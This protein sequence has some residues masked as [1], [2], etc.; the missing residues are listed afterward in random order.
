MGTGLQGLEQRRARLAYGHKLFLLATLPLILAVTAIAWVVAEQARQTSNREIAALEA[1]LIEAKKQE[2]R[3]YLSLARTAFGIIYGNAPP[4]DAVA[5]TRV[6]QIL[7]AM[8]YG[9]DGF[10]FVY[11]YDGKNIVSPRQTWLIE[12]TW[13]GL[14]DSK[15]TP[16]VDRLIDLARQGAGY[17]TYY[18]P[19]PSTGEEALMVAYV[20]GLQDWRWAVGTGIFIDDVQAVVGAARAEV[21]ARVQRTFGWIGGITLAALLAVFGSGMFITI[22]ER[23]LAD[24]KLKALTQRVLDTQEEERSRVA[25]ELHDSISQILVGVRYALEL[26]RRRQTMGDTRAGDSL[27]Q[28]IAHLN[29]AIQEVRRISRDLRPGVL[30]DLGL[31]PALQGLAEDF[32]RRTGLT[33]DFETNP[34][35]NRLDSDAKIALYRIAQE[36]LTNVERHSGATRVRM[37]VRGTRTGAV[38]RIED[39]GRGMPP[40]G[41]AERQ[42]L[43]L[44][45]MAER[46]EQLDGTL[47]ILSSK[48]GTV[49]EAAVPL[50]HM[51]PPSQSGEVRA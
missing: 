40:R 43:G 7:A 13:T 37:M 35:R 16:V 47:R 24:A 48:D 9:S 32:G 49:I 15:G 27:N 5:K 12:R 3:N 33:V 45:N 17:H 2:L 25:R 42:G 14:A 50:T 29:G 22:R 19:K 34:F 23:R 11:D 28:G 18:W 8:V 10:L 21:E 46:M 20:Q 39:N 30:D 41:P 51:L 38:L 44:R 4:D 6:A 31:G 26:A 36:A 1:A